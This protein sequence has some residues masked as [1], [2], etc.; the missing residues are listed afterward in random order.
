MSR[1]RSIGRLTTA[2]VGALLLIAACSSPGQPATDSST[3]TAASGSA[4]AAASGDPVNVGI[5]TSL[6][7]PLQSYG[8]TYL[9]AFKVCLDYATKG[10]GEVNGPPSRSRRPTTPATRR[11][12]QRGHGPDRPGLQDHRRVRV[13]RCRPAG[14]PVRRAEQGAVHLR[15]GRDRRDHR[16]EQVHVPLRAPVLPGR[17]DRGLVHRR[18]QGKKVPVFAQDSAF[19]QANVAAVKAVI[20]RR[21]AGHR[22]PGAGQRHRLR[23]VRH[24]GQ[25]AKPDLLFVAWAGT[26]AT[27]M[28][29]AL[30][31]QGVLGQHHRRHRPGPEGVLPRCSS[32][33]GREDLVPVALLRRRDQQRGR[34]GLGCRG[35][36]DRRCD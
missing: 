22:D 7:G 27:A 15:P 25:G 26:T 36:E 12:P 28:W 18:P 21:G 4:S 9:D 35:D 23:S 31:Q 5:V 20:G 16:R 24:A 30:D 11:R 14:R 13:V 8:Q 6:S 10:T 19:G 17:A 3:A 33:A 32:A 34:Q 29:G 1:P 2:S